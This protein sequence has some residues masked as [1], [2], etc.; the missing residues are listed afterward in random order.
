V[1]AVGHTRDDQLE[2]VLMRLLQ[3]TELDGLSGMR[4]CAPLP[5]DR[6]I[7]LVRP[8]L[9]MERSALRRYLQEAGVGFTE[10]Q[11]NTDTRFLRNRLRHEVLPAVEA[12]FP[13]ARSAVAAT[14][15]RLSE[16]ADYLATEAEGAI[17]WHAGCSIGGAATEL[18]ADRE[19]FFRLPGP[20]R[21]RV[22]F[23][24][25]DRIGAR[26]RRLPYRF[27]DSV[28]AVD[29]G[30]GPRLVARGHGL[31]IEL[32]GRWIRCRRDIVPNGDRGYLYCIAYRADVDE[33]SNAALE[34][35]VLGSHGERELVRLRQDQLSFPLIA[36]PRQAGDSI[37]LAGGRRTLKR[38]FQDRSIPRDVRDMVPVLEDRLG[39]VGVCGVVSGVSGVWRFGV[40]AGAEASYTAPVRAVLDFNEVISSYAGQQSGR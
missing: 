21:R 7:T 10:D 36:R 2:T 1:L 22:L 6:S 19:T 34:L 30:G 23:A 20:V 3:G 29:P 15:G 24:A 13:A 31:R 9:E 26:R 14:A 40:R 18:R 35:E 4:P 28:P 33:S 32:E 8:L 5:L 17:T 25:A 39:I 38:V 12:A 27:L 16:V 37:R 11:S